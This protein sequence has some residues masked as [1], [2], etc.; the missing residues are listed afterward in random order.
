MHRTTL[1][2][3]VPWLALLAG[4]QPDPSQ[5]DSASSPPE[6]SGYRSEPIQP[7]V[8]PTDLDPDLVVLGGELFHDVRLSVDNTLSCASCHSIADG[9]D[10]GRKTS[11]GVGGAVGP[12]N[13]PTVL[14]SGF[15]IAQ[16]WNGRAETLEEQANGPVTHPGE[17]GS[18][19]ADVLVKLSEDDTY[20]ARFA[21]AFDDGLTDLNV[22][23]AIAEYERSLV[24]VDSPFDRWLGGEEGALSEEAL[25]GYELFKQYGCIACH[26]G[27]NVGGN[28]Y[29]SFGVMGDYF[30]D[31]GD[32]TEVDAG[33]FAVTGNEIDRFR[34]RVPSLRTA[35]VTAPYFHDGTASTLPDAIR[36]M[37]R[38]Q[39]GRRLSDSDVSLLEAF[40]HS[41]MGD[42]P[43]TQRY[44]P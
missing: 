17:M 15:N 19:W 43:S 7:L 2:V 9:G 16:F 32:I 4:C 33:R 18:D 3:V 42:I 27:R 5:E 44:T 38:Y 34:F 36:V 31:R 12:I 37:G 13:A 10:D 30:A 14:N 40:L 23:R 29:Q 24:T 11:I 22:R 6:E 26:Q 20:P 8:M 25:A 41:L 39:L 1:A 21:R 35:A 28:M